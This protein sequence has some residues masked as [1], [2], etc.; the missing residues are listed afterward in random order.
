MRRL[1]LFVIA[2]FSL[3]ASAQVTPA[4]KQLNYHTQSWYS[5]NSTFRFSERWGMV[6]DFHVRKEGMWDQDRFYLLRFGAVYWIQGKYPVILGVARLWLAPPEGL[7]TWNI[8]NRIYQQWS[9]VSEQGRVAILSR[10]RVEERWRDQIVNDQVVGPKQFS[11]RLRYLASFQVKVFNQ[12]SMPELVASDEVMV[13][14]GSSIVH[15]TFDQN[16]LFL[17]IR[18]P[19]GKNLSMDTGYMNVLQQRTTGNAYDLSNVFRVFL[20]W[21]VDY[22][23]LGKDRRLHENAD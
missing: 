5:I 1:C 8:E 13:Q 16:R 23:A 14:F 21:S 2:C 12:P 4:T 15:N 20:Y 3:E 19:I 7:N 11:L 9:S 17:G 6:G 18:L 10:I 22:S